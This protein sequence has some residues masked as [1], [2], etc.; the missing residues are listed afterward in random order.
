MPVQKSRALI[1]A[2][3]GLAAI[4]TVSTTNEA[5]AQS[6]PFELGVEQKQMIP[7]DPSFQGQSQY[8]AP[9]ALPNPYESG[10]VRQNAPIQGGLQARPPQQ[11]KGGARGAALPRGFLGTWKVKGRLENSQGSQPKYREALPRVFGANTN[12]LW[13]LSGNPKSGYFFS[14]KMGAKSALYVNKVQGN[15][16]FIRYGHPVGNCTAQEAI[17]MQ[18]SPNGMQFKGL[19]QIKI[20][21]KGEPWRFKAKY[22]LVGVRQR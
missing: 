4:L 13:T 14:N 21:K 12:N 15:T 22:Q 10:G 2:G 5:F 7:G 1:L 17:V 9:Q 16:A 20:V 19:E 6:K 3:F 18:L 11:L 8:P